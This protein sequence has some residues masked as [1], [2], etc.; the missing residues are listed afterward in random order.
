MKLSNV[1]RGRNEGE[2]RHVEPGCRGPPESAVGL[3]LA[4]ESRRAFCV[5]RGYR[6]FVDL[7]AVDKADVCRQ[8]AARYGTRRSHEI[9]VQCCCVLNK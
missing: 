7:L 2:N 5:C 8:F 4:Q 1:V 9:S 3:R 6:H